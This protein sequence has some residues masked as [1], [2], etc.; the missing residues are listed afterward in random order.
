M[1]VGRLPPGNGAALKQSAP[2]LVINLLTDD[3]ED[4]QTG[5]DNLASADGSDDEEND[6][7]VSDAWE[8]SSL[9]EDA[10]EAI[11]D[12]ELVHGGKT[13]PHLPTAA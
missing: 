11:T 4:A 2:E 12:Q 8:V 10:M 6:A 3:E 9:I 13:S 7:A 1:D 5:G